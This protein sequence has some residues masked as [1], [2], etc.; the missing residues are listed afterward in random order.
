MTS[1]QVTCRLPRDVSGRCHQAGHAELHAAVGEVAY[2]LLINPKPWLR[3][4]IMALATN[5]SQVV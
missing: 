5:L 2:R 1:S 4:L 3:N